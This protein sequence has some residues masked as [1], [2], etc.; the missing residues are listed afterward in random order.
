MTSRQAE[1]DGVPVRWEEEGDG[2]P[3]VLIH[4]IPTSP[5]LWR[6]VTPRLPGV[7]VL[8]FEM[9]GY[10]RSIPAGREH[11]ISVAAQ[12][13]Y[14]DAWLD[15]LDV[16]RAVLVGHDLGGG[17]AQIAA[18]T[19]PERCA[20]LVLTN[21]IAYDSWP[22]PSVKALRATSRL[23]ARTP[24]AP[25]KALMGTLLARGHDDLEMA[26]ES[27]DV[28]Y[29]HYADADG[30]AG[31]ARQ[32]RALDVNDTLAVADRLP[33]LD[34]PARIVWGLAD[35]FQTADYGERLARDLGTRPIGITGGKHFT[36]E[37]HPGP[38]ADAV[39]D[40]VAEV[41]RTPDLARQAR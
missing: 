20:G 5:D 24:D 38:V 30:A 33:D 13:S 21:A 29:R 10:G 22:I 40:L 1:V 16:E 41:E 8:A 34:V 35:R 2:L 18:V 3:V 28:H 7:R 25:F 6:H 26:A 4:G 39:L 27:L 14:L 37:D 11:D 36:P 12:A 23:L 9:V 32:V 31:M 19:R 17:V 15:H